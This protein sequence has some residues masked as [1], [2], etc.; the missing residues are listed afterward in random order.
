MQHRTRIEALG[1]PYSTLVNG[2]FATS[3][4]DPADIDVCYL[5][6]PERVDAL[7]P[8]LQEEWGRLFDPQA[9]KAEF[10]CDPYPLLYYPFGHQ[11]FA[12]TLQLLAYWT[13]VFGTDRD[14]RTKAILLVSEQ[15][16]M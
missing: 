7:E 10:R 16:V 4:V 5:F 2:S 13:R 15:G 12:I 8:S 9:C 6:D 1:V 14:G 11:Y 3:A